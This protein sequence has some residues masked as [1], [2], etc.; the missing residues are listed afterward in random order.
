MSLLSS[1]R[2]DELRQS[3]GRRA[4]RRAILDSESL[5]RFQMAIGGERKSQSPVLSHWAFF[6]DVV[7]DEELGTDGHPRRGGFL[8]ALPELPRRMFAAGRILFE[9]PLVM[10]EL[11]ELTLTISDVRQKIGSAGDLVFI[12]VARNIV[13]RNISRVTEH[14]TI[15]FMPEPRNASILPIASGEVTALPGA[16]IWTPRSVNLFRFSAATFNVHRIH[17]DCDYALGVECYPALVVQGPFIA[18]RLAE[19]AG[20]SGTLASFEFRATAPAFVD[21]PIRLVER[22]RGVLCAIRCDEVVSMN[23]KAT[24]Q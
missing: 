9:Q 7:P 10:D 12:D 2:T 17:Y 5:Y 4:E 23:A 18:S 16:E 1:R 11:A 24:Y 13:Q 20:Q 14:Q 15:V 6:H 22:E 19:L 21:Q 8:P 3:I